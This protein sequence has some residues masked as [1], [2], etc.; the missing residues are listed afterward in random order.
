MKKRKSLSAQQLKIMNTLWSLGEATV[1]EIHDALD[2]KT[3]L[4][5]NTVATML[6]RFEKQGLVSH[7]ETGRSYLYRPTVTREEIRK[8]MVSVMLD[9]LFGGDR[10]ELVSHILS[11]ADLDAGEI[12]SVE[13]MIRS[14]RRNRGKK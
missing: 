12:E 14:R 9:A 13:K 2:G 10:T 6:S 8:S 11:A 4:A 3:K 1:V 5:R 7:E